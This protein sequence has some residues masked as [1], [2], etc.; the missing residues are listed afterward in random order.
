MIRLVSGLDWLI[1]INE[2]FPSIFF[3][4]FFILKISLTE[5]CWEIVTERWAG[6]KWK[7]KNNRNFSSIK[8]GD[9]G[10]K[11]KLSFARF[12]PLTFLQFSSTIEN[13]NRNNKAIFFFYFLGCFFL[14]FVATNKSFI[15]SIHL[16]FPY[17]NW[18]ILVYCV[19]GG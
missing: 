12:P 16:F 18:N 3:F 5:M 11:S 4:F 9:A 6:N 8:K 17:L 15:V 13:Y 1:K 2:H 7:D 19:S 14:F 10:L